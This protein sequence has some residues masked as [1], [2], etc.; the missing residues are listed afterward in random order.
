MSDRRRGKPALMLP[1]ACRGGARMLTGDVLNEGSPQGDID[2]LDAAADSKDR[3]VSSEHG[4]KQFNLKCVPFAI[5]S[6]G[7]RMH[8]GI[9]IPRWRHVGA[10]TEEKGIEK[11]RERFRGIGLRWQNQGNGARC[12]DRADVRGRSK[13]STKRSVRELID[14]SRR[15][16][17]DNRFH[18]RPRL[19]PY[20]TTI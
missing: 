16:D 5:N 13:V 17:S 8:A 10:A 4:A 19:F 20:S 11:I 3:L 2:H 7:F 6:I 1:M 15:R 12:F 9:A 14:L 18:F